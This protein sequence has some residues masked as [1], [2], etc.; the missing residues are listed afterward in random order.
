M[1]IEEQY[2]EIPHTHQPASTVT[3]VSLLLF[4]LSLTQSYFLFLI[5]LEYL[6]QI[7]DIIYFP[8]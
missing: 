6:Q 2:S 4:C 1:Y 3:R 5:L 7:L 8:P